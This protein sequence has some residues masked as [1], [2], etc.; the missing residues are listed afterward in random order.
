MLATTL[1]LAGLAPAA[2]NGWLLLQFAAALTSAPAELAPGKEPPVAVVTGVL[3]QPG[4]SGFSELNAK[5]ATPQL[6]WET[7]RAEL[8]SVKGNARRE[9]TELE[10]QLQTIAKTGQVGLPA[11][12]AGQRVLALLVS[13]VLMTGQYW[14]PKAVYRQDNSFTVFVESWT[15]DGVRDKN[16]PQRHLYALDLGEWPAG[17]YQVQL[18]CSTWFHDQAVRAPTALYTPRSGLTG[19]TVAVAVP[20]QAPA[21]KANPAPAMAAS[22]LVALPQDATP[23]PP[24]FGQLPRFSR[25]MYGWARAVGPGIFAGG[26]DANGMLQGIDLPAGNANALP[27][28]AGTGNPAV[29]IV[30]PELNS[31]EGLTLA[32][33]EWHDA[34]TVVVRVRLWRDDGPRKRNVP[35][36]PVLVVPLTP[37]AG[38]AKPLTLVVDWTALVAPALGGLYDRDAA[39]TGQLSQGSHNRTTWTPAE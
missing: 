23:K 15:D 30:G 17:D 31:Y 39:T 29:V 18:S 10:Q 3:P 24:A 21:G 34:N 7:A 22:A 14:G 35:F 38:T 26:V 1:L 12:V 19:A 20:A 8:S 4:A 11:P 13:P 36:T 6:L 2:E 27:K 37:P 32:A 9:L 25:Q 5:P 28:P 33:V 16:V